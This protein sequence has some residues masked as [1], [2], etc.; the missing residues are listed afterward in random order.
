MKD[1]RGMLH[2]PE[3]DKAPDLYAGIMAIR[4]M[5]IRAMKRKRTDS[6]DEMLYPEKQKLS[7]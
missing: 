2:Q 6:A 5:H 4:K 1:I 7:G 3:P